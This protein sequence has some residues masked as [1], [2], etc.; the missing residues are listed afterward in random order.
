MNRGA[1]RAPRHGAVRHDRGI[2]QR[3]TFSRHPVKGA[4][5]FFV[6]LA[7]YALLRQMTPIRFGQD[8]PSTRHALAGVFHP[9]QG[10][11]GRTAILL[12]APFGQEAIRLH[13]FLRVLS[14][15][16]SRAGLATLRFDY[17]GTGDS[18]GDDFDGSLRRWCGDIARADAELRRL[19]GCH[20]VVWA[21]ARLGAT[22]AMLSARQAAHPPERV[23][24][25]EPVV[26]GA[27]YLRA[28]AQDHADAL[29]SAFRA[30][31]RPAGERPAGE[32]LGFGMSPMLI[33][34]IAA[35]DGDGVAAWR[36]PLCAIS[37]DEAGPLREWIRREQ[38]RERVFDW[39]PLAEAFD[40]TAEEAMNTALVPQHAL[41]CLLQAIQETRP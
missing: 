19:S 37:R 17:F 16:L 2:A 11:T 9:A 7:P 1:A 23:V 14:E 38:A 34:E 8:G 25:W 13:R 3:L 26:D 29:R 20:R 6:T 18:D 10:T 33:E 5:A 15:Q 27:A 28:L 41:L 30:P 4:A 22:L 36:G 24:A 31:V 32:A 12:C 35:I 40:W 21:G 39:R